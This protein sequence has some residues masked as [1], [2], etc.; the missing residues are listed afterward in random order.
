MGF[1]LGGGRFVRDT[2]SGERYPIAQK[3]F[4]QKNVETSKNDTQPLLSM[5]AP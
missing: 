2:V 5:F 1:F 3:T 4:S